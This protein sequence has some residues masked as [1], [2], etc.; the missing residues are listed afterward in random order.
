MILDKE[1]VDNITL[2]II[3]QA[4]PSMGL[5]MSINHG[6]LELNHNNAELIML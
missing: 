6:M 1:F 5:V 2:E 4:K 3:T